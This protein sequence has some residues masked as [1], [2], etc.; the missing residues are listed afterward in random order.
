M[1]PY[2]NSH[3]AAELGARGRRSREQRREARKVELWRELVRGEC[4]KR[5]AYKVGISYSTAKVY[6]REA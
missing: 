6:R 3:N 4:L 1:K 2:I 5:A